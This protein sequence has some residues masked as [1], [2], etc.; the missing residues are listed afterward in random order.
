MEVE[1]S[2]K[3]EVIYFIYNE[4]KAKNTIMGKDYMLQGEKLDEASHSAYCYW[5]L[6]LTPL[7]NEKGFTLKLADNN[8]FANKPVDSVVVS[9]LAQRDITLHFDKNTH[10][11]S[12]STERVKDELQGWK[13]VLQ[14]AEF[15]DYEK[16]P[17]G[18][19]IYKHLV[20]KRD[21]KLLMDAKLSN[22]RRTS[23]LKPELFKLD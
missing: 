9:R 20:Y 18:E 8:H 23:D 7:V 19:M 2:D 22:H 21:G 4:G 6:S 11:L 3:K 16:L 12:G 5:V 15:S 1:L 17:S 13:E 14:E 10:L